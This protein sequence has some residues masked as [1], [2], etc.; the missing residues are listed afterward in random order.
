MLRVALRA[1]RSRRTQSVTLVL[2]AALV[3]AA[4]VAAPFYVYAATDRL[5]VSELKA[6]PTAQR[7]VT[8]S[9]HFSMKVWGI[10]GASSY[11]A[12]IPKQFA[13]PRFTP[14][15]SV[16]VLGR[17]GSDGAPVATVL[18]QRDG[19]CEKVVITGR[20]PSATGE[21]M[22]SAAA[23]ALMGVKVGAPVPFDADS[24]ARPMTLRV[25]GVYVP[26]DANDPYWGQLSLAA[27][28]APHLQPSLP[29]TDAMFG[30]LQTVVNS[31]SIDGIIQN[32]LILGTK[33]M[34][35]KTALDL[36][37]R[38][39]DAESALPHRGFQV[40]TDVPTLMNHIVNDTN[41]IFL[42]VP[43]G[44]AQLVLFGWF[45]L[46]LCLRATASARRFDVGILKLR[47]LP[48]RGLWTLMTEQSTVPVLVG[49]P[50][51]VVAGFFGARL[52]AGPVQASADVRLASIFAIAAAVATIVGGLVAAL[53]A[54]R[55]ALSASVG[56][57]LRTTP[58]RRRGW[59]TD[60]VDLVVVA[61]AV[62]GIVQIR[63][64]GGT[65]GS[66]LA[67]LAPGL[68]ALAIGLLTARALMP[69]AERSVAITR[70]SGRVRGL[71]TATYLA[72]RPGLDRTF[73]LLA[74]AVA[75]FGYSILAWTTASQARSDRASLETGPARVITVAAVPSTRL[76]AAVRAADPAGRYAMA[77]TQLSPDTGKNG[78]L[79]VDGSRLANVLPDVAGVQRGGAALAA[80]IRPAPVRQIAIT[81]TSMQLNATASGLSAGQPAGLVAALLTTNGLTYVP[82]GALQSGQHIYTA[83][84]PTC[85]TPP[86]CTLVGLRLA[87]GVGPAGNQTGSDA[88]GTTVVLRELRQQAPVAELVDTATF[89]DLRRWRPSVDPAAIGPTMT[90]SAQGLS[91]AV[92]PATYATFTSLDPTAYVMGTPLPIPAVA[93]GPLPLPDYAGVPDVTPFGLGGVPIRVVATE[94]V[95]PRVAK[96]GVM[97]DLGYAQSLALVDSHAE[98]S[99]VW[100]A[101]GTPASVVTALAQQGLV[102]TADETLIGRQKA[103]AAQASV[104]GQRFEVVGGTIA[105]VLA[106]LAMLVV[107]SV[108][109]DPRATELLALRRQG[110]DI[111][112]TRSVARRG[113]LWLAGGAL[114]AGLIGA[115]CDRY[116]SG[117]PASL[118][119]D[120]WHVLP[121]P[122][123]V[124]PMGIAVMVVV[125]GVTLAVATGLSAYQLARAIRVRG[126]GASR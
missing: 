51:G 85:A 9:Q 101:A 102:T 62:A 112:A 94:S 82:F 109:R 69:L 31:S 104:V 120:S 16:D 1:L 32:D 119:S 13:L 64:T 81:G 78:V 47:G 12:A 26:R 74:I 88:P 79:A 99:Q 41:T 60:V 107:A 2:L 110:V 122:P 66:G 83:A 35:V 123:L 53:V 76:M 80:A 105:L 114:V 34:S 22:I 5:T 125:A 86:G 113:Y 10:S 48:R 52:I 40:D 25:V 111:K 23:A 19:V 59:R 42:G 28:S 11:Q 93:A 75:L 45:A 4:A 44:A 50:F 77:A 56:E 17:S 100:L 124:L 115:I 30:T 21:V 27:E 61:I 63:N 67:V 33:A 92:P 15:V 37:G 95:L 55:S 68:I 126:G 46:F 84:T 49:A 97:I 65:T 43:L 96:S 108:E 89:R 58:S 116:L 87:Q 29:P 57:L 14:Q 106:A 54:E 98:A 7:Q 3:T 71:L 103:Y 91:M 73:A 70:R 39:Y 90:M 24:M 117:A 72:R 118:F 38:I 18:A 8:V 36:E 6:A 121:W 20:C